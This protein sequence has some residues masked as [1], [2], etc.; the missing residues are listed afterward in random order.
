MFL[1]GDRVVYSASDLK[2]ASECEFAFLRKL[3]AKLG[4]IAEVEEEPD[5]M[6]ERT[7]KLGDAHEHRRLALYREQYERV[8]EFVDRPEL[9][10]QGLKQ[11]ADDTEQALR[12]G[13]D[14]VFQG[15]FFDGRMVGFADFLV[16][17]DGRYEVY[18]TKLA[19]KAKVSALLQLAAYAEQLQQLGIPVGE[20]VHVVLGHGAESHHKLRDILPVYQHRRA[21]LEQIIQERLDAPGYV[22]WRDPRYAICGRCATCELEVEAHRDVL[23]TAGLRIGQWARLG[24]AGITTIDGLAASEGPVAGIGDTTL[25][26]LRA[27]A[28]VQLQGGLSY[29]VVNPRG[30]AALPPADP[31]DLFF[32]FEGDPLWGVEGSD[33]GLD[34]LFGLVEVD[35]GQPVFR[36]WW[37]HDRVQERQALLDFLA[38]VKERRERYPNLHIYHYAPYERTHLLAISARYGVGEQDVDDLLR[39]EVLVDLYPIVKRSVRVATRSYSIKKLEPLYMGESTRDEQAVQN[40]AASVDEYVRAQTLL[41]N[42]EHEEAKRILDEIAEYNE[43]DCVSTYRLREWLLDRAGE[44]RIESEA[45]LDLEERREEPEEPLSRDLLATISHDPTVWS[46]DDRAIALAAAAVDYHRRESKS[47]WWEHFDR[48]KQPVEDWADQRDVFVVSHARVLEDWSIG[49]GR[50][51]VGRRL[52]LQGALAPGSSLKVGNSPF[53]VYDEPYPPVDPR[54]RPGR[55]AAH[56]RTRILSLEPSEHGVLIELEERLANGGTEYDRIPLALTPPTPPD[57]RA[58]K[59]AIGEWGAEVSAALPALHASPAMDLLRRIPP[60]TRSGRLAPVEHDVADAITRSILDLDRSYLA[61]QGPPGTGKTFTGASVI[62]DLVL[63]HGWK[64]GIVAQGHSTIEHLLRGIV[65]CGL[66]RDQVAKELGRREPETGAPWTE[67][68]DGGIRAF[69]EGQ[70]GGFVVGGTAWDYCNRGKSSPGELDLLVVDEAGQYSLAFTIAAAHAAKNL[71]LLG[72]PQQLPQVSKG[73]HPQP[74]DT[75]AL[76]WLNDGH[77]V[78]PPELG[79]FLADSYR[80]NPALCAVVSELSYEGALHSKVER[81]SQRRLEALEPGLHTVPVEHSGNATESVQEA[82][83]VVRIVRENLG[84]EWTDA[85]ERRELGQADVIVVAPYNAQVGLIR[86]RLD[87]AGLPEVRV[88][89]V[90]KFQGQEAVIAIVSLTASSAA[91]VPRGLEFLL[92]RNRLNVAISRAQWAAYL[93]Y[94]PG[95]LEYLPISA[96]GLADLSGFMTLVRAGERE[97]DPVG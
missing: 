95:L 21:R 67:V 85:D 9:T 60:R 76:G 46:S 30:L 49:E 6:Y 68:R 38:Y 3:D 54:A 81:T 1:L 50:R 91:D 93:L 66:G 36:A 70:S 55:R 40:G 59:A 56:S 57:T 88:G 97:L 28:R 29:E 2:A 34:Y 79:Y 58:L 80:M 92:M 10:E 63:H 17:S 62:R 82:D 4:R 87:A 14:V 27:Q 19:R 22:E 72:D 52:L 7:S 90:D 31:G 18:D 65:G 78:L 20:T 73:T 13:N 15:T 33:W 39:D 83:E 5:P 44:A 75:S 37:A 86:A 51:S 43:Y 71:L 84:L 25:E 24:Q 48:L 42:G 64:V 69:M 35:T 89:T 16:H 26:N 41:Q 11:A 77:D 47:Y 53:A 32:D 61:V 23:L 12:A 94:S 45:A 8:V 74:V 96:K